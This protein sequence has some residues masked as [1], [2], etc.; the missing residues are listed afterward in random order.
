VLTPLFS[1]LIAIVPSPSFTN[2]AY[3]VRKLLP[4]LLS[5]PSHNRALEFAFA[6][7]KHVHKLRDQWWK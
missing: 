4:P 3:H 6:S 2:H 5:T 1:P 7:Y